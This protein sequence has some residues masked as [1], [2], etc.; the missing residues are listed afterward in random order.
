[1]IFLFHFQMR[2]K[3]EKSNDLLFDIAI[4]FS[5]ATGSRVFGGTKI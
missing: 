5:F 2:P 1:L 4:F 3:K